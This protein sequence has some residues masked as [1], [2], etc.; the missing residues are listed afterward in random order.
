MDLT[1]VLWIVMG[2]LALIVL[3][4]GYLI[5]ETFFVYKHRFILKK[6]TAEGNKVII[7]R[8]REL[9]KDKLDGAP[10]W[11]LMKGRLKVPVPPAEARGVT[12]FGGFYVEA[13][14][15]EDGQVQYEIHPKKV[16]GVE[17]ATTN[18]R[19]MLGQQYARAER[20]RRR[21]LNDII[22][23]VVLPL[24]MFMIL[25]IVVII[26]MVQWGEINKPG[27]E[28]KEIDRQIQISLER[29]IGHI[30]EL[31]RDIQ[32]VGAQVGATFP[33]NNASGIPD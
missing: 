2:T 21:S 22:G 30:V 4:V 12:A 10:K 17:V 33:D 32:V 27:L 26:G 29:T 31:E 24:G 16:E 23:Q 11:Q 18:Q 7:T 20:D 15:L 8:A 9:K 14:E 5:W 28:A 19:V 25:A 1:I 13:W 3:I 6:P